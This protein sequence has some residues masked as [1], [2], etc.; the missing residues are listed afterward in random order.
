M[1]HQQSNVHSRRGNTIYPFLSIVF[2][3]IIRPCENRHELTDVRLKVAS[4]L[5]RC[6]ASTCS[7]HCTHVQRSKP[8]HILQLE[9]LRKVM[10]KVFKG[11]VTPCTM[12]NGSTVKLDISV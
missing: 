4:S 8:R 7:L 11:R 2:G 1:H 3:V 12:R 6:T 10:M 9:W 5:D